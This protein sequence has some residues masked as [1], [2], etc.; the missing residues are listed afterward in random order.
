M[1]RKVFNVKIGNFTSF[2]TIFDLVSKLLYIK[3]TGLRKVAAVSKNI[4]PH[5][6]D[7][8]VQVPSFLCILHNA[9]VSPVTS[10]A[11]L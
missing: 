6:D 9:G 2:I 8:N 5:R 10:L 7:N 3:R 1:Q 4:Y 11:L